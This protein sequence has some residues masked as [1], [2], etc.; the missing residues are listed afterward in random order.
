MI[1][2]D[3]ENVTNQI[4]KFLPDYLTEKGYDLTK[5]IKCFNPHH[6][7]ST[8]SANI[9][10]TDNPRV[11]CYGC[12]AH[13]DIFDLVHLLDGKPSTGLEWIEETL[14]PLAKKYGV[15]VNTTDLTEEQIYELDTYKAYRAASLLIKSSGHEKNKAFQKELDKRKW[16]PE[17][18][19]TIGVGTVKSYMDFYENLRSQGFSDDFL[20]EIDLNRKDIFNPNSMIFTWKD[21]KGR[22]IGF[23]CR[24]LKFEEEKAQA[25]ENGEKVPSNKYINQRTTG[26]KCNIFQKGKRFFN[27]DTAAKAGNPTYIFEG[28]ADVITAR[29]AGLN[30][31]V[32]IAGCSLTEEHIHLLKDLNLYDLVL[33]LDGDK[34]GREKGA[35][36]LRD[37]FAG[38]KDLRVRVIELP[39]KEDPDSFIRE[40]GIDAFKSLAHWSAFEWKLNQYSEIAEE[41]EICKEMIPIIFSESSPIVRESQCKILAKRT[42]ISI[43]SIN[44]ELNQLLDAK[45][46]NKAKE[47]QELIDRSIYQLRQDPENAELV[48]QNVQIKLGELNK[49]HNETSLGNEDFVKALDEQKIKEENVPIGNTG[50]KLGKDLRELEDVLRGEWAEGV[51]ICIGGKPNVG[52]SAFLSKIA[53]SIAD[54]NKNVCV[55]YHTIDDTA[56]QL[57]PRFITIA[58]ASKK[59]SINMVRQPKYW[60]TQMGLEYVQEKREIGYNKIRKLAQEGRLI[61]KELSHGGDLPFAENLIS[62][63]QNKYPDRTIV[64]VLDNFHKLRDFEGKDERVRF[65]AISEATKSISIRKRCCIISSVEYTKLAPG[66]KPTNHNVAESGQIEYDASAIIHLYSEY[67]DLP[68]SFTVCHQSLDYKNENQFMP[69]VEFIVG[70]NK[71]SELK[72]SFFLDFFPASSDYSYISQKDVLEEQKLMKDIKAGKAKNPKSNEAAAQVVD[73]IFENEF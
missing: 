51:F 41:A 13:F 14:K 52:K 26:L 12:L 20:K 45:L 22:P 69:R 42:G 25:I 17:F 48:L 39:D 59:L 36:I 11:F 46:L 38:K 28:Q 18:L 23:T 29:Q 40:K 35:D 21:E 73:D 62:F 58:E 71:I 63:Y 10:G 50:F 19:D 44:N 47:R 16:E 53:Y 54:N 27:A 34:V 56:E 67:T 15:E 1:I 43:Q 61:I 55:I 49:K 33:C 9:V 6:E 7:D 57:L 24:N 70:K 60:I 2:K 64:Y 32:A 37:K 4:K 65:K 3:F 66:I 72:K 68:E 31:C 5:K 30:N 8:P